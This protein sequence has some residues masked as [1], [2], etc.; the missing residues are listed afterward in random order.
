MLF[1]SILYSLVFEGVTVL[2]STAYLDEAE[3]CHRLLLMHQGRRLF[4]GTPTDL[5]SLLPGGVLSIS[6]PNPEALQT[7]AAA[8]QGVLRATAMGDELHVVVDDPDRRVVQLRES[9]ERAGIPF[10]DM[11][12]I[13]ASVEDVFVYVISQQQEE[14]GS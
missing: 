8:E 6:S 14:Q 10:G 9:F 5:K 2:V 1:R 7:A 3:R 11:R 4:F 12:R 13:P